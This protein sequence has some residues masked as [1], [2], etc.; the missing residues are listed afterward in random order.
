MT[1][2]F[3]PPDIV[4]R[5]CRRKSFKTIERE[6]P[7]HVDMVRVPRTEIRRKTSQD[8]IWNVLSCLRAVPKLPS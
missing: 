4:Q 6:H 3:N 5:H 1:A 2:K 7:H 8:F